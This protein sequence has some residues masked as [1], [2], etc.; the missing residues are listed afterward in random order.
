MDVVE[1]FP[2]DT[3]KAHLLETHILSD[4]EN[5]NILF[6]SERL[7]GRKLATRQRASR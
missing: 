3:L 4:Q 6:K 7:G 2:Y 1:D 5:M